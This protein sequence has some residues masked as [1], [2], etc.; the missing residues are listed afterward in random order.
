MGKVPEEHPQLFRWR[1]RSIAPQQLVGIREEQVR[2]R[3]H[4][5]LRVDRDVLRRRPMVRVRA[6]AW[7]F[8]EDRHLPVTDP[9]DHPGHPAEAGIDAVA[10]E[11]VAWLEIDDREGGR[12]RSDVAKTVGDAKRDRGRS[13][14]KH[15]LIADVDA[16]C[17]RRQMREGDR[18]GTVRGSGAVEQELVKLLRVSA[19]RAVSGRDGHRHV[20]RWRHRWRRPVHEHFHPDRV[21]R[22]VVV[23]VVDCQRNVPRALGKLRPESRLI[24]DSP[25]RNTFF[26]I[27]APALPA[28]GQ[29]IVVGIPGT[30]ARDGDRDARRGRPYE[31][32]Y[33]VE[34]LAGVDVHA[35]GG[36][37]AW[38]IVGLGHGR[39][40]QRPHNCRNCTPENLSWPVHGS[41]RSPFGSVIFW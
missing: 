11:Q 12:R 35:R 25:N 33:Q 13:E 17:L 20:V 19:A 4:P 21:G 23:P 9:I 30:G 38:R 16:I 37:R 29:R 10:D 7:A 31:H 40:P 3:G 2:H 5:S 14:R 22:R 39:R 41:S 27:C 24:L 34:H 18:R 32:G 28:I 26:V 36:Y 1:S 6:V 8:T 15:R